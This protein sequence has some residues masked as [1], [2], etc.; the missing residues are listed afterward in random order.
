M[1]EAVIATEENRKLLSSEFVVYLRVST[2]T[3]VERMKGGRVPLLP[4]ANLKVFLDQQHFERDS[5]YEAVSTLTIDSISIE[6]DV[7]KIMGFLKYPA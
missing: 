6:D 7:S 2:A 1:E 5:L 4:I 3:Q